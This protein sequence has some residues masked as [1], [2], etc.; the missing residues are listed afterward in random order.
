MENGSYL[1]E[2]RKVEQEFLICMGIRMEI[3]IQKVVTGK[4]M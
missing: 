3:F 4:Q 2:L 1:G